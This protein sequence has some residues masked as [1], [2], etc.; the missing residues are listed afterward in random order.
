MKVEITD[1][2]AQEIAK[3]LL[4]AAHA[5]EDVIVNINWEIV[6]KFLAKIDRP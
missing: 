1:D 3:A 2:E 4:I 6:S 5:P